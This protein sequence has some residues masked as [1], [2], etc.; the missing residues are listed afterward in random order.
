M[1]KLP[2]AVYKAFA[3]SGRR[4]NVCMGSGS[5]H[6][7]S[8]YLSS[9]HHR[10]WPEIGWRHHYFKVSHFMNLFL[11]GLG[12]GWVQPMCGNWIRGKATGSWL[13]PILTIGHPRAI[14]ESRPILQKILGFNGRQ[15]RKV[16][17]HALQKMGRGRLSA[18]T[19]YRRVLS[20]HPV[21]NE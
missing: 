16:A 5:P 2:A 21:L 17:T 1:P 18:G 8:T 9:L 13:R 4:N 10:G 7:D 14:V 15:F 11:T 6:P 12:N 19:L 3:G 20:R